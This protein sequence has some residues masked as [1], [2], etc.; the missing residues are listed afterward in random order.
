MECRASF[1]RCGAAL[2]SAALSRALATVPCIPACRNRAGSAFWGALPPPYSVNLALMCGLGS[3]RGAGCCKYVIA[4][5]WNP[6]SILMS[7]METERTNVTPGSIV[8]PVLVCFHF[9]FFELLRMTS[10]TRNYNSDFWLFTAR[11]ATNKQLCQ[12][13]PQKQKRTWQ[14]KPHKPKNHFRSPSHAFMSSC[15]PL[16]DYWFALQNSHDSKDRTRRLGAKAQAPEGQE[17]FSSGTKTTHLAQP[18]KE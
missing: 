16:L 13:G 11:A 10:P 5:P 8:S 17:A 7:G 18:R 14:S 4:Q 15:R 3:I 2:V 12:C 6:N 1:A 9:G